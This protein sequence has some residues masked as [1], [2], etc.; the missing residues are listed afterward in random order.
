MYRSGEMTVYDLLREMVVR[1]QT[2]VW[3]FKLDGNRY[4]PIERYLWPYLDKAISNPHI[5]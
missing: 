5:V 4:F 3:F 1:S 2:G